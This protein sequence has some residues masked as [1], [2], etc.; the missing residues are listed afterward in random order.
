MKTTRKLTPCAVFVPLLS[1]FYLYSFINHFSLN[2]VINKTKQKR[3]SGSSKSLCFFLFLRVLVKEQLSF[4]CVIY[5]TII[6]SS[7]LLDFVVFHLYISL[8]LFL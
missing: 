3:K 2:I 7:T 8:F 5:T 4:I 1:L 6:Y